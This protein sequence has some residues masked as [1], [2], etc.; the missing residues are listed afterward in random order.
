MPLEELIRSGTARPIIRWG[1]P[2][3]HHR[4]R[5]VEDFGPDLW[6]LLGDMFA[7]MAAADGVGL[8]APQIGVDLAVFVFDCLDGFGRQRQGL[9]CNP[10]LAVIADPE[11]STEMEGC[12]SLPGAFMPVTR[13]AV[14]VV[15][16]QDQFGE[17]IRVAGTGTL[18]RCLQHETDHLYGTVMEDRLT[19]AERRQLRRQHKKAAGRYPDG[20]P[21]LRPASG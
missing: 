7:T 9:V 1:T 11:P 20:W 16:G 12:L 18:A 8:A 6:E 5:P 14:A 17:P 10:R 2:V 21:A 15:T 4:T 13:D 19:P 3:L